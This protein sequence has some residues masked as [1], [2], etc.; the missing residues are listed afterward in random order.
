[1]RRYPRCSSLLRSEEVPNARR[2][3]YSNSEWN[4]VEDLISRHDDTLGGEREVS[5]PSS[6]EGN[7]LESP[8]WGFNARQFGDERRWTTQLTTLYQRGGFLGS[9]GP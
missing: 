4:R 1:M 5:Q 8:P 2:G 3:G 9:R 6:G 7:N